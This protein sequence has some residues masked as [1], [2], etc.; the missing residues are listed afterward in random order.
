MKQFY[1]QTRSTVKCCSCSH[2]S[3]TYEGFSNLSFELPQHGRQSDLKECMDMY[4]DGEKIN[5]WFCPKCNMEREA[6]KKL[7]I[8]KVPP[9]LVVHLKRY[10]SML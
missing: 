3:A 9:I 4:F 2:E 8:S 7:D 10:N 1:G 5:G 6:I